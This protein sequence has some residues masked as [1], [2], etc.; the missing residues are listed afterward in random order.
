MYDMKVFQNDEF[1]KLRALTLQGEPYFIG[2]DAAMILGY[3][4]PQNAVRRNVDKQERKIVMVPD[5]SGFGRYKTIAIS[6]CGL[7]D[8]VHMSHHPAGDRFMKWI[9]KEV[10]P[11]L[12]KNGK[13]CEAQ[14]EEEE[15][16][17]YEVG[18]IDL[19]IMT[20]EQAKEKLK[21][22]AGLDG[23]LICMI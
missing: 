9:T 15:E 2:R 4:N 6:E 18:C 8:L 3:A 10:V 5:M 12:R 17:V 16:P 11:A 7:R 19:V 22:I 1:G 13:P 14:S 23:V 20:P 21:D